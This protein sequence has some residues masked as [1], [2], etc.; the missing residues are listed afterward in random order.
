MT[1]PRV[2][3]RAVETHARRAS[4][5]PALAKSRG[6]LSPVRARPPAR[7]ACHGAGPRNPPLIHTC[8]C[9]PRVPKVDADTAFADGAT[10]TFGDYMGLALDA[11]TVPIVGEVAD[12]TLFAA[13]AV[14]LPARTRAR[15]TRGPARSAGCACPPAARPRGASEQSLHHAPF[16]RARRGHGAG[17]PPAR[18]PPPPA[19]QEN[20]QST[21]SGGAPPASMTYGSVWRAHACMYIPP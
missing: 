12:V 15:D 8:P 7:P 14:R 17:L 21:A 5:H 1:L 20:T 13:T 9:L 19:A 4:P 10:A 2:R 11:N 16:H 18:G 6:P 3:T